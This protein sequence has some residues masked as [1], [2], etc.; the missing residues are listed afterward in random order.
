MGSETSNKVG[1]VG[2]SEINKFYPEQVIGVWQPG[3][4]LHGKVPHAR[5]DL[6]DPDM[7]GL[8]DSINTLGW[9]QPGEVWRFEDTG[10]LHVIFGNRRT[11]A[12]E[13]INQERLSNDQEAIVGSYRVILKKTLTQKDIADALERYADENNKRKGND[14][15]TTANAAAEKLRIGVPVSA[16]LASFPMIGSEKMLEDLTSD[17]GVRSAHQEVQEALATGALP[18]R[19]A[20]QIARL[21]VDQQVAAMKS[22]RVAKDAKA[23]VVLSLPKLARLHDALEH[24]KRLDGITARD[25]LACMLGKG[26]PAHAEIVGAILAEKNKPGRKA[27]K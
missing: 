4:F 21:P 5:Y 13:Q 22:G 24:D 15:L 9:M 1:S 7:Q 14:W 10:Q 26:D 3:H 6:A 19:K 16:V 8:K 23:P 27:A 17:V 11:F 20:M 12:T 2:R 18:I 25:V